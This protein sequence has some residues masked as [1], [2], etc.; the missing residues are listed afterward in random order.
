M[1]PISVKYVS[2][3]R[4]YKVYSEQNDLVILGQHHSKEKNAEKVKTDAV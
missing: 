1:Y 3:R 4:K 2:D